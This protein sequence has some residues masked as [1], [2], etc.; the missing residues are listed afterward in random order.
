[1]AGIGGPWASEL[2]CEQLLEDHG[3]ES[4]VCDELLEFAVL[5][6]QQPQPLGVADLEAAELL[7][8]LIESGLADAV[9]SANLGD[10][11]RAGLVFLEDLDDLFFGVSGSFH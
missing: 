10:R 11:A 8:P 6:F 2:F 5:I 4:L 9:A 1:M 3:I 7:L